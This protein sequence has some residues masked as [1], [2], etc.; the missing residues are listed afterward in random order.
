MTVLSHDE[1]ERQT[2][3][4]WWIFSYSIFP[5]QECVTKS[6]QYHDD[7]K[8]HLLYSRNIVHCQFLQWPLEF[9]VIG[10]RSFVN[11]LFLPAG[12]PLWTEQ[13]WTSREG[14]DSWCSRITRCN[15]IPLG[16]FFFF[17]SGKIVFIL[18][19]KQL[20]KRNMFKHK[21]RNKM[22]HLIHFLSTDP[23]FYFRWTNNLFN[24][25]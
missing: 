11:D 5:Y 12:C 2:F 13:V 17:M 14:S 10:C 20:W 7:I 4:F 23:F 9:F 19:L 24:L 6:Q 21:P 3:G 25:L 8:T 18:F 16:R 15:A 22:S 1:Y